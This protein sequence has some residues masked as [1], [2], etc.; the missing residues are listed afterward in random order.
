MSFS[1]YSADT[2]CHGKVVF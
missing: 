1:K 2:T